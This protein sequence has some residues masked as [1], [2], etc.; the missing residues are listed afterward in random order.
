MRGLRLV[1]VF[2]FAVALAGATF[3]A[4]LSF[5]RGPCPSCSGGAC[6]LPQP[7]AKVDV[8]APTK[9]APAV[10]AARAPAK[11][12]AKPAT[13][14]IEVPVT[15][16]VRTPTQAWFFT[17]P[18]CSGCIRLVPVVQSLIRE[19]WDITM[20]DANDYRKSYE[21]WSIEG[22]PTI[23]VTTADGEEQGRCGY[24]PINKLRAWLKAMG[25]DKKAK[26]SAAAGPAVKAALEPSAKSTAAR[27]GETEEPAYSCPSGQCGRRRLRR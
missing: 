19:G 21:Q 11:D 2:T 7:A 20:L 5:F 6:Q 24:Q 17:L 10:P 26:S 15:A 4:P 27:G 23:L 16:E 25:V 9:P 18:G 1:L 14:T 13:V 8:T 22:C 3:A 12:S